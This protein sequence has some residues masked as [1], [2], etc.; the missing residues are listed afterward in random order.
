MKPVPSVLGRFTL[1]H[2]LPSRTPSVHIACWRGAAAAMFPDDPLFHGHL[3]GDDKRLRHQHPLVQYRWGKNGPVLFALGEATSKVLLHPWAGKTLRLGDETRTI[4]SVEWQTGLA[5]AHLADRLLRYRFR[6]PWIALNQ[7]NHTRWEQLDADGRRA[8]L[9]RA[10]VSHLLGVFGDIGWWLP[11]S[12]RVL[13]AFE[14]ANSVSVR[15]KGQSLIGFMGDFVCN[16]E[17]P[18]HLAIGKSTSHG[19]GWFTRCGA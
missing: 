9:D 6:A 18:D 3:P 11:P 12:W 2:P 10:I 7:E 5:E 1:D 16:L 13:G 19:H 4:Q 17:L 8:L 15:L 14:L